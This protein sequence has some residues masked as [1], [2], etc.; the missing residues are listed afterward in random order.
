M[1]RIGNDVQLSATDL[2]GHL[3]CQH[4]TG[5]DIEVMDGTRV[6]PATWDPLLKI[7]WERG[8]I[9]ERAYIERLRAAGYA[10]V[11]IEGVGI[12]AELAEQ[13]RAAMQSG[14][15][16]IVQGALLSA[17][18]G[19]RADVLRRVER[20]S[21]LGN[22]SYEVVDTK[23]A[24]ETKAATVLQL[25][26]YSDLLERIQGVLPEH[27]YVVTPG[28]SF[29]PI[30]F[31]TAAFAAY[32]RFVRRSLE[33]AVSVRNAT[34]PEPRSHCD[35][36]R[37]RADCD[38]K[39]RAD[40]HL[41]LVAGISKVQIGELRRHEVRTTAELAQ[42]ST[43]LPWKPERGTRQVYERS[44]NQAR[45]QMLGRNT[46]QPVH[47][48][49][50][51]QVSTGLSRLPT[52]SAGDIFFD[53]EGDP[54][55]GEEGLEY[56]FGYAY[57]DAN[58]ESLYVEDWAFTRDAERRVFQRFVAFVMDRWERF[59]DLHIYHYAPYEPAALKRLMGRY[60]TCEDEID[61]MLR[62]SLFVDLHSITRQSVR[63]SVESYT[64]KNLEPFF[65][66]TRSVALPEARKGLAVLQARLELDD[67]H[68]LGEDAP[69]SDAKRVVAG[70]NCDDCMSV[71]ALQGWLEEIR[72][73]LIS[74]GTDIP[75]PAAD[76]P[77]PSEQLT[78]RQQRLAAL[79]A[80]LTKG[81]PAD[82]AQ[83]TSEQRALWVLANVLDWHRRE[84]KPVWWERFRL[85]ALTAEE[86]FDERAALGQLKF[87]S[88]VGG[89]AKAP[90]HRYTFPDQD[91]ELRGDEKLYSP[92]GEDLGEVAGFSLAARTI[93]IKK[94]MKT[95]AVHPEGAFGIRQ[96]SPGV[97]PDALLRIGEH[98][99][100]N[101]IQNDAK[102]VAARD[103]LLRMGPRVD[104]PLLRSGEHAS[105]EAV[106]LVAGISEGVLAIQGPPGSGKTHTAANMIVALLERG[107]R[108]GITANSH[109]V[110]RNL[111]EKA[112]ET[113][114]RRG[115][116]IRCV[117]K[118]QEKEDATAELAFTT[119]NEEV[120]EKLSSGE[121]TVAAGT[122]W[123]WARED[124]FEAVDVLFVDEAAQMSLAN[125][126]AVSQA[127]C[128]LVLLGD[129]QQLEQP[130]QGSHPDG[131]GVSALD[132]LLEGRKTIGADKGLFLEETRRLH[133]DICR[134]TSELF[135]EGR[136]TSYAD[137]A[138]QVIESTSRIRGTG[139]RFIPVMHEGNQNSSPEEAV[140][141][142]GLVKE[143]LASGPTWV[144]PDRKVAPVTLNDILIVAPY[145][146]QVLE[147]QRYLPEARIGTVDKF[148]GQE[149]PVVIFSMATSSHEDAPRGMSFLYNLN[150]LNVATSRARC[151]CVLVGSP[152]LFE[153]ECRTPEQMEMANAFCRYLELAVTI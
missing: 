71:R 137:C 123:L 124:A 107:R 21:Q 106:R 138:H 62:G 141:I 93:D 24:R 149:A 142:L 28:R 150:R 50:P 85:K 35:I 134:F 113:A 48:V 11:C 86:L 61:R 102:Y 114:N 59:P 140:A 65:K 115:V 25:S 98:V 80:R 100:E 58:G 121:C 4:L 90:I 34:Y 92:G 147:L 2:T 32:F 22:W 87:H 38:G 37:W 41:C 111:L 43:P 63:A 5:L 10:A 52:P 82:E 68:G 136:L 60:A 152:V 8:A 144:N 74:Q 66:F 16:V 69:S 133:P 109:K 30:A 78:E 13:T 64:L 101:G 110:I 148:Q 14:V 56:L 122:A 132:H 81:I 20:S 29:E 103:L 1:L 17:P 129:P 53:I 42:L 108:V 146:A 6:R 84:Q 120:F 83:R 91:V 131:A 118:V 139:L 95:A 54:F 19:G 119:A 143:F 94:R 44:C 97:L 67:L 88:V 36:C 7:L 89:S 96:V 128:T 27:M 77:E 135:Y 125:V 47:K 153:P 9:H 18:W 23:L 104:G 51:P 105:D 39:W 12:T 55:V 130:M 49:I 112:V 57:R 72:A 26:L 127:C 76:S 79:V 73:S 145:N 40:D 99:A 117:L 70:Y 33:K 3:N 46:G 15:E 151:M 126:L 75:R 116:Q 45:V 31:R